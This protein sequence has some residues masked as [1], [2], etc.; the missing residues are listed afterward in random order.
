MNTKAKGS[1]RNFGNKG[2][3]HGP[4]IAVARF[5]LRPNRRDKPH[6]DSRAGLV[7]FPTWCGDPGRRI[8]LETA[9]DSRH[10]HEIRSAPVGA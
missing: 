3:W 2:A 5:P 4:A 9:L 7:R 10:H 6:D 8:H 1:L